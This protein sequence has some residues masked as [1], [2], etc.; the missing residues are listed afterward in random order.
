ML[1]IFKYFGAVFQ[2]IFVVIA[3]IAELKCLALCG[4]EV[5]APWLNRFSYFGELS[6]AMSKNSQLAWGRGG[7]VEDA[8]ILESFIS[9]DSIFVTHDGLVS[10]IRSLDFSCLLM[11][12]IALV[13]CVEFLPVAADSLCEIGARSLGGRVMVRMV[14][15]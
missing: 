15:V 14:C 7:C 3:C 12:V 9:T 4:N 2:L 1:K 10:S 13:G 8:W 5:F 6:C 11:A